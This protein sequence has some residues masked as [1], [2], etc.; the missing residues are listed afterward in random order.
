MY[1]RPAKPAEKHR[2]GGHGQDPPPRLVRSAEKKNAP[3][4][5]A[6]VSSAFGFGYR[7]SPFKGSSMTAFS[8]SSVKS[9]TM[10]SKGPFLTL[11]EGF[12]TTV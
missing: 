1:R 8:L 9:F 2:R 7:A 3:G 11:S 5:G 4:P 6:F 10:P 12:T